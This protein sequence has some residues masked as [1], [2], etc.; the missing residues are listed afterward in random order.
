[1]PFCPS[2]VP[3]FNGMRVRRGLRPGIGAL[4]R[5]LERA[6]GSRDR[7][8]ADGFRI[9]LTEPTS[10]RTRSQRHVTRDGIWGSAVRDGLGALLEPHG[11][12]AADEPPELLDLRGLLVEQLTP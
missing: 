12:V 1:M 7:R 6:L 10:D 2:N 5:S 11:E 4:A 9:V 8:E 3:Y